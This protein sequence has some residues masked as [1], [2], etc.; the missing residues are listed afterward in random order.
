MDG[1]DEKYATLHESKESV[2]EGIDQE[3]FEEKFNVDVEEVKFT[4]IT[5]DDATAVDGFLKTEQAKRI[6]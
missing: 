3:V 6:F 5:F 4:V 2:L 1:E